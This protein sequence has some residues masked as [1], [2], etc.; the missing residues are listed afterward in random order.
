MSLGQETRWAP[1]P[2][3][4]PHRTQVHNQKHY[5]PTRSVGGIFTHSG[6][7]SWYSGKNSASIMRRG[8]HYTISTKTYILA[9]DICMILRSLT[10]DDFCIRQSS[11]EEVYSASFLSDNTRITSR[12]FKTS[13][14]TRL[15]T[16]FMLQYNL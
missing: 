1:E 14:I 5:K 12:Q 10:A 4:S 7:S 8:T 13:N 2:T 3:Q 11:T 6:Q 16:I 9:Y 15:Y